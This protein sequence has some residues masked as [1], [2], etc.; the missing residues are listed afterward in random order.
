MTQLATPQTVATS[1]D[2]VIVPAPAPGASVPGAAG[3][4]GSAPAAPA[5]AGARG[6]PMRLEQRGQELWAEFADPDNEGQ[7]GAGLGSDRGQ[8]GVRLGSDPSLTPVRPD[9]S[10]TPVRPRGYAA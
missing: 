9:P 8:A 2:D 4:G 7:T 3:P 5:P 10:L 6:G 1:F